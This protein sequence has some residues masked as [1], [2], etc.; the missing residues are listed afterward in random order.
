[1]KFGV[2]HVRPHLVGALAS[3][4]PVPLLVLHFASSV[5]A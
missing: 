4:P 1:M 2:A 3:F 5:A